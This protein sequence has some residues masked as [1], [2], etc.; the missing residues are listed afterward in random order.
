MNAA[1]LQELPRE[2]PWLNAPAASLHELRGRPV[3]L[4]F[5]NAASAWCAQRLAELAQWQARNP[6]RLQ[7]LVVQV[8]RF[9]S[10]RVPQRS[11]KLLRRLGVASPVLLDADWAA[12]QR[13]GIEA[14]PTLLLVDADGRER[15]RIVGLGGDMERA[16]FALVE[17]L[18]PPLEEDLTTSE[19]APEPRLTLRFPAGIAASA[20]RLYIADSGHHRILEC[21]HGG[22]ILRQFGL[23]T[24]D[25]MDG[26]GDQAAFHRP[27]GLA[28]EREQLFVADTGNHALRRI[29]LRT[30][31]VDTLCGNGRPGDPVEGPVNPAARGPLNHPLA[32]A[33]AGNQVHIASAG[34][35]RIWS[36]DLGRTELASSASQGAK[37]LFA[38]IRKLKAL[39]DYVQV[40][41]GAYAGSACGRGLSANPIST[42]G[43]ERRHNA[44]FRID[45]E[46][47]FVRHMLEDLPPAPPGAAMLRAA[48]SGRFAA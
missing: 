40:L 23:G 16:L 3:V 10:E 22:R 1:I 13:Y 44:A 14:W 47:E 17:G 42:I 36:C 21:S 32:L 7:V 26:P 37:D 34:D 24:A 9:D 25:F 8:P 46:A 41:P 45:S 18:P 15:E 20:D 38:S 29:Q 27:Q 43:F 12:W 35:N 4:A 33:V 30:G 19:T 28:L 31:Q 2:L 6:G 5:V 11:L 48:N 39:P